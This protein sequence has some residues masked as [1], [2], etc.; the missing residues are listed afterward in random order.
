MYIYIYIICIYKYINVY[1]YIYIYIDGIQEKKHSTNIFRP[2]ASSVKLNL[3]TCY[4]S[5]LY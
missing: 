3:S 2:K 1:I 4:V 5:L